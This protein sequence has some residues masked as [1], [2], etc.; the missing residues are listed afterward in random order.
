MKA[1]GIEELKGLGSRC[2][3]LAISVTEVDNSNSTNKG[4]ESCCDFPRLVVSVARP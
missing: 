4:I 1:I 2:G 3:G